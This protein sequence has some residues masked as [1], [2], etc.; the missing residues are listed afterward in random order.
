VVAAA[1]CPSDAGDIDHCVQLVGYDWNQ[2]YWIVR[3]SWNTNWGNQGY[4]YLD[5]SANTCGFANVATYAVV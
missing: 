3:N 5:N 4:I 1:D 2:N